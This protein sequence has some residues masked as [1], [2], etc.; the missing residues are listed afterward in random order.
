MFDIFL[1]SDDVA[2]EKMAGP[3]IRA[4]E[5]SRELARH[6]KVALAVPD[7]SERGA[8]PAFSKNLPFE[9]FHYSQSSPGLLK[10]LG[11]KSR[12]VLVQG[13]ILSKFP[14]LRDLDAYLICD[15][16]V[17]FPLENLFVH[18]R[19]VPSLA[20]RE[21]IHLNDLR[22]FNDQILHG[23]HFLCASE[24]QRDLFTGSLL[25]L[26]RINPEILDLSPSLDDLISVIPFGITPDH[27]VGP[28]GERVLRGRIPAIADDDILLLWGGVITNWYDPPTLLAAFRDALTENPKLK[29]VFLAKGHPN[30][31]LPEFDMANEAVKLAAELGLADKSVFFNE[32]WVEYKRR[33]LYF[34]EADIGVSIHQTHFE[35][36]YSFRIRLLDYLKNE[37]P[38]LCTKGDYFAGLVEKEGLGIT[39]ESGDKAGLTRAILT[40][41]GDREERGRIKSRLARIKAQ[42][43]WETTAAPLVEH[44]RRVIDGRARKKKKP[45]ARDI[46]V[47][48]AV[49]R[50][51]SI[52]RRV[53]Q[54]YFSRLL[55]KLP[56]HVGTRIKKLVRRV[57]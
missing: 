1:I 44:C 13:Y 30:P 53:G 5:L 21:F 33:G 57:P 35:T 48:A 45:G 3:G 46:A 14:F 9:L 52:L 47:I 50:K 15:L 26:D 41:A 51:P 20:D 2:G 37:L 16:Y 27:E 36:Y 29:L 54:R 10:E 6:F 38:I 17:P 49:G 42:F 23:D 40:L 18:K 43:F 55:T 34:R 25:S 7:Y 39:V 4:W 24:R 8:D 32:K 31:L 19:K 28:A 12:I 22:V 56:F 11:G